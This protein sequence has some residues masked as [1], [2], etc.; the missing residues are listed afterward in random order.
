MSLLFDLNDGLAVICAILLLIGI[1]YLLRSKFTAKKQYLRLAAVLTVLI[2]PLLLCCFF[3]QIFFFTQANPRTVLNSWG[4]LQAVGTISILCE[5]MAAYMLILVYQDRPT[6][7]VMKTLTMWF[8]INGTGAALCLLEAPK[9]VWP[10]SYASVNAYSATALLAFALINLA[11]YLY[12]L[13]K[14][15]KSFAQ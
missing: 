12:S 13:Y 9:L 7:S 15:R 4:Y 5:V 11:V 2:N 1:S 14:Y 6:A 3:A 10:L 8:C